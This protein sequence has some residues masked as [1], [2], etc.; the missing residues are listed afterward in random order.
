MLFIDRI[1]NAILRDI[2][3]LE[4]T[5]DVAVD[6]DYYVRASALASCTAGLYAHQ[7]WIVRQYFPDT[8]DS[9]YLEMHAKLR[10]IFRKNATYASGSLKV[11]G[12]QGAIINEGIQVKCGELFYITKSSASIDDEGSATV[13]VIALTTGTSSNIKSDTPAMFMAAPMGVRTECTLLSDVTGGTEAESDAALL[14]RLLERIRRPPSGGNKNDFRQWAESVDGVTS[15]YV[16]P[17]RRGEGTVDIDNVRIFGKS[18]NERSERGIYCQKATSSGELKSFD[19]SLSNIYTQ[20]VKRGFECHGAFIMY[21]GHF[22]RADQ[23]VRILGEN[24]KDTKPS[25]RTVFGAYLDAPKHE[26]VRLYGTNGV[27]LYSPYFYQVG[28]DN[29]DN[30][31][32]FGLFLAENCQNNFVCAPSFNQGSVKGAHSLINISDEAVDNTIIH[33]S[34]DCILNERSIEN[35]RKQNVIAGTGGWARFN[36]FARLNRVNESFE[37]GETKTL[38]FYLDFN[39][40]NLVWTACLFKGAWISRGLRGD[41]NFG[42]LSLMFRFDDVLKEQ[43]IIKLS[44]KGE[45]LTSSTPAQWEVVNG[46][47]NGDVI[48]LTLKNNSAQ[49]VTFSAEIQRS[50]DSAGLTF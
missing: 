24:R 4:P 21:N 7:N 22:V 5:A 47:I 17:L 44:E 49:K 30:V 39:Y 48:S 23:A 29:T 28:K 10:N 1:R 3:S 37:P 13:K 15:A 19:I 20:W 9:E 31:G 2:Q 46:T 14:N 34:G 18:N 8:A 11:F 43:N 36:N 25:Q 26:G 40:Q 32:V 16:Y 45:Y 41:I 27:A 6:S 50:I 33:P 38:N 12:E 42:D 35:I